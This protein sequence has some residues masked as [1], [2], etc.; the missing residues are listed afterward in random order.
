LFAQLMQVGGRSGR[1]DLPG[2]VLIQTEYPDHPLYRALI[3]HDYARFAQNQLDERRIAGFPPFSFQAMLRA[4]ARTMEQ[5]LDFLAAARKAAAALAEGVTLY[6]PV[7]MR[8]QRLMTLERGQLLVESLSRPALQAF[9]AAWMEQLYALKT[10][11]GLRWHLDVDP[12][13]F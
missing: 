12:L 10:P 13:E 9:L 7:P 1:A 2:E 3:D 5:A 6:D 4:E 11:A 8:L